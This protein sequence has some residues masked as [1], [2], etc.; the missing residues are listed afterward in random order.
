M[1]LSAR[2]K[3]HIEAWQ[4]SG[5]SQA[6]YCRQHGLNTNTFSGR[7]S[8]HRSQ[9]N[10][11][12][13]E[14]IPVHVQPVPVAQDAA[15]GPVVLSH[16]QYRLEFPAAVSPLAYGVAA[17]PGLIPQPLSIWLA[18]EP[19][20]MRLG[21]DGLS[22]HVQQALRAAPCDGSAYL[23]RNKR[24]NRIKLLVWDGN[25][26]WLCQRR[27]H[28]GHFVWPKPGEARFSLT[29][30]QWQWLVAGVDWQRLQALPPGLSTL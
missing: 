12:Q 15:A 22:L 1:A 26:V 10:P 24:G 4:A 23:F 7:L 2:W 21:A 17:M 11:R 5:L 19:V 30:E 14:L 3:Q 6:E 16:R 27:L 8:H 18:V 28:R 9:E 20:D 13:P 29:F 25:G